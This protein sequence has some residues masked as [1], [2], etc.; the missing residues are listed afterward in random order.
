L[1]IAPESFF[2]PVEM[3]L[4]RGDIF[5]DIP[6]FEYQEDI[7]DEVSVDS[8]LIPSTESTVGSS[9][10]SAGAAADFRTGFRVVRTPVVAMCVT[11]TCDIDSA[12]TLSFLPLE[13][14]SGISEDDVS[15]SVLFSQTSGY[16]GLFGVYD[17]TGELGDCFVQFSQIFPVPRVVLGDLRA[18]KLQSLSAQAHDLLLVKLSQ[19]FGKS[20][21]YSPSEPVERTGKYGC[22]K[23]RTYHSLPLNEVDV[24]VGECPPVCEVCKQSRREGSWRL[25]AKP[26]TPKQH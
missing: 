11:P 2:A 25:L 8:F 6:Y 22:I 5:R 3:E 14:L 21:G 1:P 18:N 16:D 7:G 12:L 20:W 4:S 19:Y 15:R 13:P 24:V 23:C 17:P 26:K 10:I 9:Y